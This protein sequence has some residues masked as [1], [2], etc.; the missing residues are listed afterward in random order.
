MNSCDYVQ[1]TDSP[2]ADNTQ[3]ELEHGCQQRAAVVHLENIR[4]S[5]GALQAVR[6]LSLRIEEGE[7]FGLLGPNGAGKTTTLEMMVGL[8]TPDAGHVS[9]LG[10]D[11]Q[12]ER[13]SLVS[14]IGV[15]PQ[16][17]SLFPTLRVEE[18]L[19]LFASFYSNPT[20]VDRLLDL[21]GLVDKRKSLVKSLSG[22]QRQRLLL[23]IALTGDPQL[24]FLDEPTG[25]LDPQARRQIWDVIEDFRR[26]GRTVVLTTHSMEEAQ[27][28]CDR[29]AIMDH[30]QI[31]ALATPDELVRKYVPLKTICCTTRQALDPRELQ[32]LAGVSTVKIKA[33]R[34]ELVTSQSDEKLRALLN[35]P[36]LYDFDVRSG[37]LEDVFLAL[38]GRTIRD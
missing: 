5:Y 17:A 26:R 15:Q 1:T 16:E 33:A 14:R 7:I 28:L 2:Q 11:P 8:R 22:G 30:G 9:I 27:T 36:G 13:L 32:R 38:T 24:L 37:S 23:G 12:A 6:D 35:L 20:G 29:V 19:R 10:C 34:V 18:T 31:I 4:K 21:V 3:Q 25:S